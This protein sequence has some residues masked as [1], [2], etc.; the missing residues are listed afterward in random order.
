MIILALGS[1]IG[2][3]KNQLHLA[4]EHLSK[5]G[6]IVHRSSIYVT[7]PWGFVSDHLFHNMVITIKTDLNALELLYATQAI[8]KEMGRM[9]KTNMDYEDRIID[10]DIIAYDQIQQNANGLILPHPHFRERNF[11]LYPMSEIIPDWRDPVTALTA[12]EL[13]KQSPDSD[14]PQIL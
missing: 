8:E 5:I 6:T 11:V 12:E 4:V 2:N 3:G 14:I 9:A 7:K 1:N 10:I 13:K